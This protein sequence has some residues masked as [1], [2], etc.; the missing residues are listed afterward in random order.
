MS[1]IN[2]KVIKATKWSI[3]TEIIVKIISP[4]TNMILAR[5]LAPEAFGVV[6]TATMITSF[7][8]I[9]TDAGF[10][11]YIIQHKFKNKNEQ[12]LSICVAFWTNL[13]LS[14][15]IW[16][17]ISIFSKQLA[18]LVGNPG[19]G[20]VICIAASVLPL[21]SFSSIQMAIYRKGFDFKTLS[22]TRIV[23]KFIPFIVTI[24]LIYSGMSYW[25]LIIGNIMG[26]LSNAIILT[27][28]SKWK[29][30]FKYSFRKLREMFSFCIWTLSEAISAWMVSNVSIFI[31]GNMLS[32]Y[33]L[34]VYKTAITTVNQIVSIISAS[35]I[36]VL[37]S[38][39][40]ELQNDREQYNNMVLKF[41]RYVGIL[42]IPLGAGIFIFRNMVTYILLGSQWSEASLIIGLWGLIICESVI[43]NDFS[44]TILLSKGK[45]KLIFIANFIQILLTIPALLWSSHYSFELMVI[46]SAIIR[47]QLPFTQTL[48]ASKIT[49]LKVR[50]II[51]DII[52]FI[53]ATLI[54]SLVGCI[55]KWYRNMLTFNIISII[56]CV[57]T[58]FGVLYII[59][60]TRKDINMQLRKI[61]SKLSNS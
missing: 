38:T 26:E 33:Y 30:K 19:L 51:D 25:A 20:T 21:T 54:M 35:T 18:T 59:P 3:F 28:Y 27:C 13:F 36:S 1:D 2:N 41:Q 11:K 61:K 8:D 46:V 7:S 56:V 53:G 32:A 4:I 15:F 44:G 55:L 17:I 9:F 58:Y 42:V 5:L 31:I 45:P 16:I 40:S 6:A 47:I 43:L 22:V 57:I 12:D 24:P 52:P 49:G 29:P 23:G 60:S 34:G 10:Q 39:L 48:M 37:F 50:N 14:F